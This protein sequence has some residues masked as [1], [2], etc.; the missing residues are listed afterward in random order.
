MGFVVI[1]MSI[2]RG[3]AIIA[4]LVSL[5]LMGRVGAAVPLFL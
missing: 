5:E 1:G 3:V 2:V 4:A